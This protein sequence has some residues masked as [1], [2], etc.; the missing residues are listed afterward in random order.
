MR[1]TVTAGDL[2]HRMTIESVART[3]DGAGGATV[4]WNAVADVSVALW[5]RAADERF[6]LDRVAGKATHDIWLRYRGDLKPEMR[7][8][9]GTRVFDILGVIDVDD[10]GRWLRCPV[11]ERDQ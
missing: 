6:V 1:A 7:F 11:E 2:R 3:G 10:R 8:R 4:I 5:S 9:F